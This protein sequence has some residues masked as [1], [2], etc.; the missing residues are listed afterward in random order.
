LEQ[1]LNNTTA[2]NSTLKIS[3]EQLAQMTGNNAISMTPA[4]LEKMLGD[5]ATLNLTLD[6]LQEFLNANATKN[7]NSTISFT[8]GDM[9]NL[10]RDFI[11]SQLN[12]ATQTNQTDLNTIILH[13][14]CTVKTGDLSKLFDNM[15]MPLSDCQ[16]GE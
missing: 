6:K 16:I 3:P 11:K 7:F 5:N 14:M 10:T 13:V 12:N 8:P 15:A 9:A 1:Y 4:Q 2:Q